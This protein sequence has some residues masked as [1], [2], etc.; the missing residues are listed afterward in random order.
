[1]RAYTE[2][3]LRSIEEWE[4]KEAASFREAAKGNGDRPSIG[5]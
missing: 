5:P 2:G 1:L 3:V 4:R